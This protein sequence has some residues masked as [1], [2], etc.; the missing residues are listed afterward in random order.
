VKAIIR[1]AFVTLCLASL[2]YIAGVLHNIEVKVTEKS[3]NIEQLKIDVE[4]ISAYCL[5]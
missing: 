3:R 4:K 5:Q 1:D 2:F